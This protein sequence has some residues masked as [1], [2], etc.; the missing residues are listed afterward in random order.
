MTN[1]N[2]ASVLPSERL[3]VLLKRGAETGALSDSRIESIRFET[4]RLFSAQARR[5]TGGTSNSVTERAAQNLL[6]SAL[7]CIGFY[8]ARLSDEEATEALSRQSLS[9]LFTRGMDM[10]KKRAQSA[11]LLLGAVQ[12]SAVQTP[13]IAYNDTVWHGL[14]A[15]FRAYDA[16][17][18]AH[19]T[20]GMIDYPLF[21]S[22]PESSGAVYAADYLESLYLENLFCDRFP[23]SAVRGVLDGYDADYAESLINIFEHTLGCALGCALAGQS[24]A[25]CDIGP[26]GRRFI[27]GRFGK[28]PKSV[29]E[30]AVGDAARSVCKSLQIAE[31]RLYDY[32]ISAAGAISGRIGSALG[33][34][35]PETIFVAFRNAHRA[36]VV[37]EDA[38]GMDDMALRALTEEIRSCRFVSDKITMITRNAKSIGD[39]SAVLGAGCLSDGDYTAFFKS[40]DDAALAA[41]FGTL[42]PAGLYPKEDEEIWVSRLRSHIGG[43]DPL[44]KARVIAT[45]ISR[46]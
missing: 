30:K 20:P 26:E 8:L 7:Y 31:G 17:F 35:R 24:G 21:F 23:A 44:R 19:D 42:P 18:A 36:P 33:L 34:S 16:D 15:F 3:A 12:K 37:F 29:L 10:V 2:D 25:L 32:V 6:D 39:L 28:A 22:P 1:R 14:P 40:L 45:G 4:A 5:Y 38:A 13:H 9:S 41:L 43:M 11:K 27:M 46:E